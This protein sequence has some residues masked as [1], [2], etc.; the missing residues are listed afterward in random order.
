[1]LGIRA[2]AAIEAPPVDSN[3]VAPDDAILKAYKRL[4]NGSDVRGIAV[5]GEGSR[6]DMSWKP[7]QIFSDVFDVLICIMQE[8]RER[9]RTSPQP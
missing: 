6:I 7:C 2:V 1:M 5:E 9:L 3:K 8:S 4:Q